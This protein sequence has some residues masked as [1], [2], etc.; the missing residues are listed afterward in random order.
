MTHFCPSCGYNLTPDKPIQRGAYDLTPEETYRD[1]QRMCITR[2]EAAFL[3][4]VAAAAG[5]CVNRNVIGQRISIA[6][7]PGNL[8]N[9]M[10]CR[11]RKKGVA[12][13]E[14]VYGHGYRWAS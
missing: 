13:F 6:E 1:G 3:Y 12:P 7:D 10:A 14:T 5:R 9:V 4:T 11:L 8:A 2:M